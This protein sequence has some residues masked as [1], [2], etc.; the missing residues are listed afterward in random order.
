MTVGAVVDQA[1]LGDHVWW[2]DD[3]ETDALAAGGRFVTPRP[4]HGRAA[5]GS[6]GTSGPYPVGRAA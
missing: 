2:A 3:D 4:R 5:A 6:P 1:A